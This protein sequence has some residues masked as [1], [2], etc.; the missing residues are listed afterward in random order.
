MVNQYAIITIRNSSTRLPNKATKI[1]YQNKTTLEI[2][3]ERA[4]LTGFE[5]VIATSIDQSDDIIF[6]IAKKNNIECFRGAL[7]NK[8]N[9]WY[10]CFE[11]FNI[12]SALL[13]DGDDLLYDFELGKRAL[14]ELQETKT[15]DMI[16]YT[17]NIICG[18]FTYAVSVNAISKMYNIVSNP[19]IDTDVITRYMESASLN[20]K[21]IELKSWEKDKPYRLTLDYNED[22]EMFNAILMK[23]GYKKGGKELYDSLII[24][25]NIL[26]INQF[27]Q[28]DYINNQKEFNKKVKDV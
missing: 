20:I 12:E 16:K 23:I 22:F 8:I 5:V 21:E 17:D 26:N 18:L 14:D 27:R 1:I 11:K 28:I 3:I 9:R 15:I 7:K 10:Y 6:E 25:E 24:N 13:I 19:N 4:K 2:V